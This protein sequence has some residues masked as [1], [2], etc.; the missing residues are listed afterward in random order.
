MTWSGSPAHR[1][2]R[3]R[4]IPFARIVEAIRNIKADFFAL[5][6]KLPE[7]RPANLIDVSDEMVIFSDT[8]A[9]IE[10]L[11]LVITIDT[12]VVHVA[13][14]IG[15]ETW[16]LL[17]YRYEWRWGLEGEKNNW[18]DSVSVL[19]QTRGGDWNGLLDEVFQHRLCKRFNA[20]ERS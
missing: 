20:L 11:D 6:T 8:A 14:A 3:R 12:S 1:A 16:L 7:I 15:K 10:Q 2:D 4:S 19:R 9:L 17:P 13:G 5:Q 18:Y